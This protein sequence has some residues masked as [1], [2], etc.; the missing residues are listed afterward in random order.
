[1]NKIY[2]LDVGFPQSLHD[3]EE[4]RD[5]FVIHNWLNDSA[6]YSYPRPKDEPTEIQVED[7]DEPTIFAH[8]NFIA[9]E[10][11]ESNNKLKLLEYAKRD[12]RERIEFLLDDLMKK[13][14]E[15]IEKT[16]GGE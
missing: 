2:N 15:E 11:N 8:Y 12:A 4:G 7:R 3:N 14:D 10:A 6:V 5:R 16:K 13:F 9:D 1:M